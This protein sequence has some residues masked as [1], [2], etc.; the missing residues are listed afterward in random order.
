MLQFEHSSFPIMW[1]RG[2]RG[3]LIRGE[4]ELCWISKGDEQMVE[5]TVAGKALGKEH[6]GKK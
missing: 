2:I 6:G 5:T 4:I 1:G 3:R